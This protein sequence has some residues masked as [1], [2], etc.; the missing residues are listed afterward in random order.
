MCSDAP[1]FIETGNL[2]PSSS[3][4]S[5]LTSYSGSIAAKRYRQKSRRWS[6]ECVLLHNGVR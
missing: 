3:A 2:P 1:E 6:S 4:S 5:R